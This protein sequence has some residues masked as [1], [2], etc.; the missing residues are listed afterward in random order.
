M[1]TQVAEVHVIIEKGDTLS[2]VLSGVLSK[3]FKFKNKRLFFKFFFSFIIISI[4]PMFILSFLTYGKVLDILNRHVISSNIAFMNQG[5][6][7]MDAYVRQLQKMQGQLSTNTKISLLFTGISDRVD[8]LY[9]IKYAREEL[10]KYGASASEITDVMGIYFPLNNVVVTTNNFY[11]GYSFFSDFRKYKSMDYTGCFKMLKTSGQRQYLGTETV[12]DSNGLSKRVITCVQSLPLY[13]KSYAYLIVL[14]DE[15]KIWKMFGESNPDNW[16]NFQGIIDENGELISSSKDGQV[17]EVVNSINTSFFSGDSGHFKITK[18]NTKYIIT[19]TTS[20][21]NRW[22]YFSVIPEDNIIERILPVQYLYFGAISL[23]LLLTLALSWYLSKRNYKPIGDIVRTIETNLSKVGIQK[24]G[25]YKMI[26]NTISDMFKATK[27][28]E[29]KLTSHIN[30]ARMHFLL[31]L[32]KS[33]TDKEKINESIFLY[34]I[35]LPFRYFIVAVMEIHGCDDGIGANAQ[36]YNNFTRFAVSNIAEKTLLTK[37]QAYAVEVDENRIALLINTDEINDANGKNVI[38][39]ILKEIMELLDINLRIHTSIGIGKEYTSLDMVCKSYNEAITALDYIS[40]RSDYQ[41]IHYNQVRTSKNSIYYPISKEQQLFN[42]V[43][44]G[45]YKSAEALL[46]EIYRINFLDRDI[47]VKLT[48]CL[49]SNL[50]SSLLKILEELGLDFYEYFNE[51]MSLIPD[52]NNKGSVNEV[53]EYIKRNLRKL[54]VRIAE[55]KS[56]HN[57]ELRDKIISFIESAYPDR[58]LSLIEV[59]DY[60]NV[61]T[62]YLSRF[63]KEQT[64]YNFND[65][66]NR[67]RIQKAKTILKDSEISIAEIS[68]KIG[69]NSSGTFI[70]IFKRYESV[71]P[72]Q[73]KESVFKA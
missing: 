1:G 30:I 46:D 8:L 72:G 43:K 28:L 66:L 29:S 50:F 9:D 59:A 73:Y 65:Y 10:E 20:G 26:H 6:N 21:E 3:L 24:S 44:L 25:E 4:I 41:I 13:T 33:M 58:N 27:E 15:A 68:E 17:P 63:F 22:K 42:H 62:P 61:T 39:G 37:F 67:Y 11:E 34:S 12:T 54:C 38:E 49:L 47:T 14:I 55:K 35:N 32:L 16:E 7:I 36:S 2:T 56:S 53:F 18:N 52:L 69:Y 57:T 48:N 70:R 51:D 5:K 40:I 45:D 31:K 23:A 19:Y 71:T 60:F 64:G